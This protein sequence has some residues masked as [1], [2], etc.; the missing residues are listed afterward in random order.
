MTISNRLAAK[1]F[2]SALKQ[3]EPLWEWN[4]GLKRYRLTAAGAKIT[5]FRKGWILSTAQ[6]LE[7]RHQ[8]VDYQKGRVD[9]LT[10]RVVLGEITRTDWVLAMREAIKETY[11]GLYVVAR[12]GR[13]QM[14]LADFGRIGSMLKQQFFGVKGKHRGLAGFEADIKNGE[15]TAE[16]IEGIL[17]RMQIRA[18]MY[19][20]SAIQA[21]EKANLIT[22][23][24]E[25]LYDMLLKDYQF[26]GDG[27]TPCLTRCRCHL[28]IKELKTVWHIRWILDPN[29]KH[30]S[31]Q[32]SCP[33]L[34]DKW[35]P[36]RIPKAGVPATKQPA[37]MLDLGLLDDFFS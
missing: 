29:A 13:F 21:Y 20:D 24:S 36:L 12:G 26:P 6:M 19:I 18:G 32:G 4:A 10:S 31:G 2:L 11:T 1:F 15:F 22:Q 33:E 25:E 37:K 7:M 5:G 28:D 23:A 8:F 30:C 14:T 17:A 27:N 16:N 35:K 9:S 34:A 3:D